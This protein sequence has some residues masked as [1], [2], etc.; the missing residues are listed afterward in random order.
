[1]TRQEFAQAMRGILTYFRKPEPE[2][3]L[4]E[5]WF[6]ILEPYPGG[7]ALEQACRTLKHDEDR[8]PENLPRAIIRR[9]PPPRTTPGWRKKRKP[10]HFCHGEGVVLARPITSPGTPAR[11]PSAWRCGLCNQ[12]PDGHMATLTPETL[13]ANGLELAP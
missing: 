2:P 7:A 5:A 3:A 10:C 11:M 12:Q 9:L 4:L 8:L 1:M 13:A 6:D